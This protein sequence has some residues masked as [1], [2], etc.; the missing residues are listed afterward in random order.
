MDDGERAA[1]DP[2]AAT[3]PL[4]VSVDPSS[5]NRMRWSEGD[6]T[7]PPEESDRPA[8]EARGDG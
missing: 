5:M 4:E 3:P 7:S 1:A 6:D 8:S 2:E